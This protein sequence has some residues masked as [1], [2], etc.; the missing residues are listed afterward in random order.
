MAAA[1]LVDADVDMG[2][3]LVRILDEAKFPVTGAA[4]IFFPDVGEWRLV[5]RTPKAEKNLQQALLEIAVALDNRGDLR[6]RLDLSR[7]KVVPPKDKMLAA[8]GSVVRV[9]GISTVRFSRNVIDGVL[10]DDALIY[11]LAA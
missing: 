7:V 11:R 5:I 4:W 1:V 9:D 6:K 3:E 10:I 2:G 8:M